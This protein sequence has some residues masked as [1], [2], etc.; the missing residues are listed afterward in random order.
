MLYGLRVEG[1]RK[2]R[3]A[4]EG[5][6][7]DKD[8]GCNSAVQLLRLLKATGLR[9]PPFVDCEDA[10]VTAVTAGRCRARGICC[11]REEESEGSSAE[12]VVLAPGMGPCNRM[13]AWGRWGFAEGSPGT[14]VR[15]ETNRQKLAMEIAVP[16]SNRNRGRQLPG[17]EVG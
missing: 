13:L 14:E 3:C 7:V 16:T 15:V 5:C 17:G 4:F 8:V 6:Q 11:K 2:H 12:E 10:R 9:L 1:T